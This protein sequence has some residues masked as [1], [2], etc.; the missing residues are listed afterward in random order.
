MNTK[1]SINPD[2]FETNFNKRKTIIFDNI[3]DML[4]DSSYEKAYKRLTNIAKPIK[5][6]KKLKSAMVDINTRVTYNAKHQKAKEIADLF[7]KYNFKGRIHVY[8]LKNRLDRTIAIGYNTHIKKKIYSV[9][10]DSINI[11]VVKRNHAIAFDLDTRK[12]HF[13]KIEKLV[14]AVCE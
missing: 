7:K 12:K 5:P 6:D 4:T 8:G 3:K 13:D 1:F 2:E 11:I 9:F 14:K 10:G